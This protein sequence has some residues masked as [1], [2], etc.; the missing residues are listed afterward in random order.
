M[1]L[2]RINMWDNRFL[3]RCADCGAETPL[4]PVKEHE[5]GPPPPHRCPK[6]DRGE[7]RFDM[8]EILCNQKKS[9]EDSL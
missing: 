5:L 8:V 7:P 6:A 3:Y 4:T 9:D 2:E 1:A